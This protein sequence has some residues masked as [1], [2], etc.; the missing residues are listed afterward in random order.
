[1]GLLKLLPVPEGWERKA[2]CRGRD[3]KMWDLDHPKLN[4]KGRRICVY[5]CTVRV[6]CLRKALHL[7][8]WGV[9]RG[10]IRFTEKPGKRQRC[11]FCGFAVAPNKGGLC[12]VCRQYTPCLGACGRLVKRK[13]NMDRYYCKYCERL[14]AK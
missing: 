5:E 11:L 4:R 7:G 2:A 13:P 1:M 10:G 6:P 9:L 14:G 12:Y 8:D 3:P